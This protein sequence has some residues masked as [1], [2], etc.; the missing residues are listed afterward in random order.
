MST[1]DFLPVAAAAGA[2]VDSQADFAGSGYQLNGF[3]SGEAIS[4]QLNK[5]WRQPSMMAAAWANVIVQTLNQDVPDDGNLPNLITQLIDT[6]QALASA[7]SNP[8][9]VTVAYSATPAFD[10]ASANPLISV[11]DLTITGDVTSSTLVGGVGGQLL[12]LNI[13]QNATGGYTFVA[14]TGVP[15]SPISAT[16]SKTSTQVF[17]NTGSAWIAMS[18]LTVN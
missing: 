15:M 13:S 14:P 10:I 8:K 4:K 2:N 7:G 1:T 16:A 12:I 17:L 6:I 9:V 3:S 11:F 5:V 18:P